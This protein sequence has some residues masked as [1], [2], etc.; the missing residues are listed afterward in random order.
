ME[1]SLPLSHYDNVDMIILMIT[2]RSVYFDTLNI[3][4]ICVQISE[5]YVDIIESNGI[6]MLKVIF[7]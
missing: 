2:Q 1:F 4:F 7:S 3:R 6:M 5:F